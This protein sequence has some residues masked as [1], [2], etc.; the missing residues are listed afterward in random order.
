VL[1]SFD[2]TE[3]CFNINPGIANNGHQMVLVNSVLKEHVQ[4]LGVDTTS[5]IAEDSCYFDEC[6]KFNADAASVIAFEKDFHAQ[7][8]NHYNLIVWDFV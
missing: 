8:S 2:L 1:K 5:K 4:T 6:L 3:S 7:Y